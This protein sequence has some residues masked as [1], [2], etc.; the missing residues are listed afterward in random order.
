[1]YKFVA[2]DVIDVFFG[3]GWYNWARFEVRRIKGKVF[4]HKINGCSIPATLFSS[5][6][7]ELEESL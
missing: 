4:L 3:Q 5:I 7:I 2:R 1:M 6:C